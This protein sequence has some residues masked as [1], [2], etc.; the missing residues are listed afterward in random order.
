MENN[1]QTPS[2]KK[3]KDRHTKAHKNNIEN[4][5]LSHKKGTKTGESSGAPEGGSVSRYCSTYGT[6]C[7]THV[8]SQLVISPMM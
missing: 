6:C 7:V 5:K 8:S 2:L 3:K 4:L 1:L